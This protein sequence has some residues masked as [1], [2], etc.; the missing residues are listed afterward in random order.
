MFPFQDEGPEQGCDTSK[1]RRVPKKRT[2]PRADTLGPL[3]FQ[4]EGPDEPPE[5]LTHS[6]GT[7]REV[8]PFGPEPEEAQ[9]PEHESAGPL[10]AS[11]DSSGDEEVKVDFKIPS[12]GLGWQVLRK[13]EDVQQLLTQESGKQSSEPKSKRPYNNSQRASVAAPYQ[14]KASRQSYAKSGADQARIQ[15]I[16][17]GPCCC[18]T[19]N[20]Y[21][22]M[23]QDEVL[24]FL[25]KYWTLPREQQSLLVLLAADTPLDTAGTP[26]R[27][28]AFL[29]TSIGPRCLAVL[30]GHNVRRLYKAVGA[31][32]DM[33]HV[34]GCSKP[35]RRAAS[36]QAF[37]LG[38]YM[39]LAETL[40]KELIVRRRTKKGS[41]PANPN[42][43]DST[44]SSEGVLEE[45]AEIG[46]EGAL[47]QILEGPGGNWTYNVLISSGGTFG[48]Q[49]LVRRWL[50]PGNVTELH[51][52]Y[53]AACEVTG[54][55]A[56][57]LST[58]RRLFNQYWSDILKFRAPS[59]F[60]QCD[61][62][63]SFKGGHP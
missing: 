55:A 52:E 19:K 3:P 51:T 59:E 34:S 31:I 58:F 12:V 35:S 6:A 48:T 32:A 10:C 30:M 20:C 38:A 5:E 13:M 33:R 45:G 50:P 47:R 4:D 54:E 25:Q 23:K 63:Y 2:R 44:D 28:W 42:F 7:A 27:S 9:E 43:E 29:G 21:K 46:E 16:L 1:V 11:S 8:L 57:S 49:G 36:C 60:S 14:R 26:R 15:K 41:R 56:A 40:P 37:L 17:L 61:V 18:K 39:S 22:E 53:E 62:C 24:A